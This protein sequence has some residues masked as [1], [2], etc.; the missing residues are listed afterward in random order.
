MSDSLSAVVESARDIVIP[1]PRPPADPAQPRR[2]QRPADQY[3]DC[4]EA[5]WRA[6]VESA[7]LG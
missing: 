3:W 5:R 1:A 2:Q 6:V 7:P 4:F